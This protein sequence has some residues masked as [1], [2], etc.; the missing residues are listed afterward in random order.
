[1]TAYENESYEI[2][3]V[4][5]EEKNSWISGFTTL[6]AHGATEMS[7]E[8]ALSSSSCTEMQTSP[9]ASETFKTEQTFS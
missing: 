5:F 9:A 7:P 8:W 6:H 1:M 3:P 4:L 2:H